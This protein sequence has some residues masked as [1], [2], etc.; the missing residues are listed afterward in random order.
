MLNIYKNQLL[1]VLEGLRFSASDFTSRETEKGGQR[2]FEICY[3][4]SP[5]KF[6]VLSRE[7]SYE[8]LDYQF[9]RM[10]PGFPWWRPFKSDSIRETCR[11]FASWLEE[12]LSTYIK[13]QSTPDL[14]S[15][16]QSLALSFNEKGTQ[17]EELG[18]FTEQEKVEIRRAIR[19]LESQI[20]EN[21]RLTSEQIGVVHRH[22]EYL[23]AALDRLNRFDWS[24]VLLNICISIA[25]NL[26]F[27][28]DR[29]KQLLELAYATFSEIT[30]MLR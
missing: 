7:H 22:F 15:Q 3:R 6:R 11:G 1:E 19:Q 14:W 5:L 30:R 26:S 8:S 16:L 9:V 27:D 10:A 24:G 21:F 25:V 29:G 2:F 20:A 17:P 12:N 4:D 18:D 28:T 13:E 23:E